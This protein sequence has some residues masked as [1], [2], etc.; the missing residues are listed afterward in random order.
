M[1]YKFLVVAAM[2]LSAGFAN[3]EMVDRVAALV[4]DEVITLSEVEE[5]A[6]RVIAAAGTGADREKI[7]RSVLDDIVDRKLMDKESSK[8]GINVSPVE[9]DRAVE[10]VMKQNRL[11]QSALEKALRD[12]EGLTIPEYRER[13]KV[14]LMKMKLVNAN[15]RARVNVSDEEMS[16]WYFRNRSRYA[17]GDLVRILQALF[18]NKTGVEKAAALASEFLKEVKARGADTAA[19]IEACQKEKLAVFLKDS[20]LIQRSSLRKEIA[21]AAA[22]LKTGQWSAPI[23]T[24]VGSFVIRVL[25]KK[26]ESFVP[27]EELKDKIHEILF[28]EKT[29]KLFKE[30]LAELRA[31]AIIEIRL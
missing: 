2:V 15:V 30:W 6:S 4:D 26:D 28:Q 3:A 17:T 19:V 13:L 29:E 25:E 20:G 7:T 5:E 10:D 27:F 14:Q 1:S 23:N 9:V 21:D 24:S 12:E 22:A 31:R 18:P 16:V 8:A 11:D